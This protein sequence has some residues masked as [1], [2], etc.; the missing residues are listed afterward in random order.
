MRI[1]GGSLRG[2]TLLS[3]EGQDIRPTLDSVRENLFNILQ[4]K[5]NGKTFLDVFCGTGAVGIE[6]HSRGAIVTLNDLNKK[7]VSLAKSNLEKLN[8]ASEVTLLNQDAISLLAGTAQKF[9]F[10]FID[11]PYKSDLGIRALEVVNRVLTD[12]GVVIFEDEKPLDKSFEGLKITNE[13]KYGRVYLTF[14]AKE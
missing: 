7:S 1:V 5:I 11:P 8:I 2:R 12:E 9:D 4:F 14:L 6:A 3:F 13:R 10:V